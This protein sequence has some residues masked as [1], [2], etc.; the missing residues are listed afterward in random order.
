ML[1]ETGYGLGNSVSPAM[2]PRHVDSTSRRLH[3]P[4]FRDYYP[5]WAH[6]RH[7][8]RLQQRKLEAVMG[9]PRQRHNPDGSPTRPHYQYTAVAAPA[10][11]TDLTGASA[12]RSSPASTPAGRRRDQRRGRTRPARPMNYYAKSGGVYRVHLHKPAR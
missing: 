11:P 1:T 2:K 4:R 12:E 7:P 9:P 8:V 5:G 10:K 3:R 6:R